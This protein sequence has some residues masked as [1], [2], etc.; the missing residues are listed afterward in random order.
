MTYLHSIC[1]LTSVLCA[2]GKLS[3]V[4]FS[5]SF[6]ETWSVALTQ[7]LA[8]NAH[9]SCVGLCSA[10]TSCGGGRCAAQQHSSHPQKPPLSTWVTLPVPNNHWKSLPV[11]GINSP[12]VAFLRMET[13][14]FQRWSVS[15]LL[16]NLY[17][18]MTQ[19]DLGKGRNTELPCGG[20]GFCFK[21]CCWYTQKY[22][23]SVLSSRHRLGLVCLI[24]LWGS[25][26]SCHLPAHW[27]FNILLDSAW[28]ASPVFF[29]NFMS[30]QLLGSWPIRNMKT[31]CS[32]SGDFGQ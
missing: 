29:Q 27:S 2:D 21:A 20:T 32:E 25:R 17:A 9:H 18:F 6:D 19:Q 12:Y 24:F 11:T 13:V 28:L 22:S 14:F 26:E 4:Q 15:H 7:I 3:S 5:Q 30:A 16:S 10:S 8:S 31:W 23:Y 1:W